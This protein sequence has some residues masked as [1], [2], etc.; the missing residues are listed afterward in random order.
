MAKEVKVYVHTLPEDAKSIKV[1][2]GEGVNFSDPDK[3]SFTVLDIP[4]PPEAKRHVYVTSDKMGGNKVTEVISCTWNCH[5]CKQANYVKWCQDTSWDVL[6]EVKPK[7]EFPSSQEFSSP[8][9]LK[10][11]IS[12]K[13]SNRKANQM[14]DELMSELADTKAAITKFRQ[15]ARVDNPMDSSYN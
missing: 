14:I 8:S 15:S 6:D 5:T 2:V 10:Y 1:R 7:A 12:L 4:L 3:A 13:E 11:V 9:M